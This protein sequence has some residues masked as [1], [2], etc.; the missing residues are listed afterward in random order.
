VGPPAP[1]SSRE[2]SDEGTNT[3]AEQRTDGKNWSF[4][5]NTRNYTKSNAFDTFTTQ[6]DHLLNSI[7]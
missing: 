1:G 5:I 4:L 2:G 6:V 7:P 3:W